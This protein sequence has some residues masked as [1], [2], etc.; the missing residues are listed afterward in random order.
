MLSE[1]PPNSS[2]L[3]TGTTRLEEPQ[4]SPIASSRLRKKLS[5]EATSLFGQNTGRDS[6]AE[7]EEE[8]P[9][10]LNLPIKKPPVAPR[11]LTEERSVSADNEM[12]NVVVPSTSEAF[13]N[14]TAHTSFDRQ[15]K[16]E[17]LIDPTSVPPPKRVKSLGAVRYGFSQEPPVSQD[18][19][20]QAVHERRSFFN[21]KL[22]SPD[23]PAS[24]ENHAVA[25]AERVLA[26]FHA[27]Y[28]EHKCDLRMFL[29]LCKM[30]DRLQRE[31]RMLHKFLWDDFIVRYNADYR[32]HALRAIEAGEDAM[33]YASFYHNHIDEPKYMKLIMTPQQLQEILAAEV[34]VVDDE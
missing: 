10:P 7:M 16:R 1:L 27:A 20:I 34:V 18:P 24:E 11:L 33:P 6:D 4:S 22:Q 26:Q 14:S 15:T 32:A 9:K 19:A 23:D 3:S 8:A 29:G 30:I 31:G 28:P 5:I 2:A 13:S 17:L 12:D 25:P 21:S